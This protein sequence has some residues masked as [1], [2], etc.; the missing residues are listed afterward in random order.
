MTDDPFE[1][2]AAEWAEQKAESD[3]VSK[4]WNEAWGRLPKWVR[5]D[6]GPGRRFNPDTGLSEDDRSKTRR[7][8]EAR[9]K[10]GNDDVGTTELG[11]QSDAA[12]GRLGE[13]ETRIAETPTTTILGIVAKLRVEASTETEYEFWTTENIMKTALEAAE[14]LLAE[15]EK[16]A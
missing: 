11:V 9:I 3:R 16:A 2:L 13:I 14:H 10:R 1:A 4:A 5:E 12:L 8:L 6:K 7:E 15:S